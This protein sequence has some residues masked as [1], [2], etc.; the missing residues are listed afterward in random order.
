ML[1]RNTLRTKGRKKWFRRG[2][3][4]ATGNGTYSGRGVKGQKARSGSSGLK[5]MAL[6]RAVQRIPKL[7]GFK[8]VRPRSESVTLS[9]IQHECKE[10][11][12]VTPKLLCKLGLM[13]G[14]VVRIVSSPHFKKKMS[15]KHCNVTAGARTVIV[16]AGGDVS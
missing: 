1:T 3:G 4:N 15:F 13:K 2:R 6:R 10:G 7:R 8:A 9:R 16:N 5:E 14:N 11:T 12:V